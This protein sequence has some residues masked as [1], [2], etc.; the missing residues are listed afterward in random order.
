MIEIFR[1]GHRLPRDCRI[2]THVALSA[3]AFGATAM[4]Y[5]GM[6]D[7]EMEDAVHKIATKFGGPFTTQHIPNENSFLKQKKKEG[8]TFIHL[9]VYGT[10][11]EELPTEKAT[12]KI[13]VIVGGE[14]VPPAIYQLSDYNISV[15]NQPHSEVAALALVLYHIH[16][17]QEAY[18]G[19][20]RKIIGQKRG[21]KIETLP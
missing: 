3:R 17:I 11:F 9:T 18:P 7:Q 1:L 21:K 10:S 19:A 13:I 15:G 16:G 12:D 4:Y 5:S 14:K 20:Q 6:H 8:Y 2:T